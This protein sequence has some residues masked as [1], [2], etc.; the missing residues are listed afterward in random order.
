MKLDTV[1]LSLICHRGARRRAVTHPPARALAIDWN[2]QISPVTG[3]H[4]H[5][6]MCTHTHTQL[7]MQLA[8]TLVHARTRTH[9]HTHTQPHMHTHTHTHLDRLADNPVHAR[10]HTNTH[11]QTFANAHMHRHTHTL[12][13]GA[14][15]GD[16]SVPAVIKRFHLE[17]NQNLSRSFLPKRFP[18]FSEN[19]FQ[20]RH[21]SGSERALS[22]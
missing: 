17:D 6:H 7:H 4:T 21:E 1:I 10:I 5:T 15:V 3:T 9:T 12:T 16:C 18:G 11:M 22:V 8:Q 13:H 20:G 2:L 14:A 19:G